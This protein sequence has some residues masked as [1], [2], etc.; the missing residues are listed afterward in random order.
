MSNTAHRLCQN[1]ATKRAFRDYKRG[2][3]LT[4]AQGRMICFACRFTSSL[5]VIEPA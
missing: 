4:R 1:G 5:K 3:M 2:E